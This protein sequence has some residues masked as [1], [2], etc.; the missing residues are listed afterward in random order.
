MKLF[1]YI[2]DAD[3]T[4]YDKMEDTEAKS[5]NSHYVDCDVAWLLYLS[6]LDSLPS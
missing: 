6:T 5:S 2:N 3:S 4:V 1:L